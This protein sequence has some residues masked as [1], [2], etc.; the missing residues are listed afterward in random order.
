MHDLF[1]FQIHVQ[2]EHD[3]SSICCQ[4]NA[5]CRDCNENEVLRELIAGA[6]SN[7]NDFETFSRM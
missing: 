4:K 7:D 3:F 5:S 6:V 2:R 1:T